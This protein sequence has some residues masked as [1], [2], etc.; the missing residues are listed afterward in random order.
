MPELPIP[1][2]PPE[3]KKTKWLRVRVTP[4]VEA[5][6]KQAADAA[7]ITVSAWATERLLSAAKREAKGR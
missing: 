4:E 3:L 2:K 7:G 1:R 6:I 5:M